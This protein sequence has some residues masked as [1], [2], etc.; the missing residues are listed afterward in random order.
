[1]NNYEQ[2]LFRVCD[3]INQNLDDDLTLDRLSTVSGFS[4]FHFHRVFS[5]YTGLSVIK[6]IQMSRLKRASFRLVFKADIKII[7]IAFEAGF[8]SA[9]AFSRAFKREFGQSPSEFRKSPKWLNWHDKTDTLTLQLI[10]KTE[11]K[12]DVKVV[13]FE[14]QKIAALAHYGDPKLHYQT[15]MKFIAWRKASKLSP[16]KTSNTYGIPYSDPNVVKAEDFHFDLCGSVKADI[17]ENEYGVVN[18]IIPAGRCAVVRDIGHRDDL[19]KGFII[20]INN[21][22]QRVVNNAEI[23]PCFSI[24]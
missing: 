17:P 8:E 19:K 9:E 23:F 15:S 7:D 24:M 18:K 21:G 13:Y 16:I 14:E 3:Y 20:Y 5:A 10:D 2:N 11:H 4:K 22:Y 12:M 1:M 6:F